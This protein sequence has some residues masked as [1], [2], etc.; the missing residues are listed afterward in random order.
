MYNRQ[1]LP[2][3]FARASHLHASPELSG[4]DKGSAILLFRYKTYI[5]IFTFLLLLGRQYFSTLQVFCALRHRL[6]YVSKIRDMSVS[7]V[8]DIS[9]IIRLEQCLVIILFLHNP[10]PSKSTVAMCTCL[11]T[12]RAW[13][14]I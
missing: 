4:L 9:G 10:H 7:E 3:A 5:E 1:I 2:A 8:I 14:S 12:L 11:Q 6:L 13:R